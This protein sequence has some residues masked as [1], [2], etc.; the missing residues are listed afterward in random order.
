MGLLDNVYAATPQKKKKVIDGKWVGDRLI[1]DGKVVMQAPS[2]GEA[3]Q[4]IN[5][6]MPVTG[7]IQSG[8]LAANDVKQGDYKSAALNAVGLL[9]FLP[10][11]AAHT[12]WHGSPHT[13]DKFDM[14]KIGTGEGAQAYGHGLYFAENPNVASN[15]KVNKVSP[16]LKMALDDANGDLDKAMQIAT[17]KA[18][19]DAGWVGVAEEAMIANKK[20]AVYKVDI[21]DEAIPKMLDWDKPLSEQHPDVQKV[22]E[23]FTKNKPQYLNPEMVGGQYKNPL[24][25]NLY[26][27]VFEESDGMGMQAR[28]AVTDYL[29][30]QGILGI[31]YLD[32]NSRG[33]GGTSNFVVFDDSLPK[34][35]ERN[36]KGLLAK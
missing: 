30:K 3:A 29:K 7:D 5:S 17:E 28:S 16:R 32:G 14:S 13:F 15:Y 35:L 9:P 23:S 1:S 22:W 24:G 12:V 6:F 27:A 26:G 11:M 25:K 20:G 18:K 33:S 10:S 21:P 2:L 34:I 4:A 36:G 31:K 8:L 19:L